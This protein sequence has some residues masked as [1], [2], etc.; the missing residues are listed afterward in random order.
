LGTFALSLSATGSGS[1]SL[2]SNPGGLNCTSAAGTTSGTCSASLAS[3]TLVT[4]A[5]TP[6]SGS[7]FTGWSGACSGTS[8]TCALTMDAAKTVT[9]NFNSTAPAS[10]TI[11]FGPAP[12]VTVGGTGTVSA[13][14]SSGLPVTVS[15]STLGMCTLSGSMVRGVA[16]G[17]CTLAAHQAGNSSFSPAGPATLSFSI[18]AAPLPPGPPTNISITSGRGSAT[19][20]FSAPSGSAI[21]RYTARCAASGQTTRTATGA[22]S[23]LTVRNLSGGALYQCTLTATDG[24]GLTSVDSAPQPVTPAAGKNSLTPI[25]LLLLD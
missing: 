22:A 21:T 9:A 13:T 7:T 15:S 18:A 17:I 12:T 8:A 10:Q 16:A 1:G 19:L 24:S 5:A 11:T 6:A 14:A 3:G 20:I 25:L 2:S 4:L 23:P